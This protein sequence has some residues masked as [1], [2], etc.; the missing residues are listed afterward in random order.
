MSTAA[1][2]GSIEMD[3]DEYRRALSHSKRFELTNGRVMAKRAEYTTLKAQVTCANEFS[4]AFGECRKHSGGFGG[5]S[6]TVDLS[7]GT[8]RLYRIPDAAFWV[9]GKPVGPD[10]ILP[11][12]LAVEIVSP[13]QS[14]A[15]LREKCRL[16]RSRAVEVCWLIHP[17]ERWAEVWEDAR[18]GERVP[19][20]ATLETPPIP[21][22]AV[23][24]GGYRCRPGLTASVS[25]APV[26]L[27]SGVAHA[28]L[29]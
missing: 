22:L 10:V 5:Q 18:D 13:D 9:P 25:Q 29:W 4:F 11:P 15:E 28:P 12:T 21:G 26:A 6:P 2:L 14:V 23:G 7:E 8:D 17:V 1:T 24:L 20:D 27:R 3:E 16:Y 19:T